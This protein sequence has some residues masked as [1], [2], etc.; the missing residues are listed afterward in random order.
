MWLFDLLRRGDHGQAIVETAFVVP[1]LLFACVGGADL[2]RAFAMQLAVQNGARAGAE[3]YALDKTPSVAA[4][5]QHAIDEINRTPGLNATAAN[6][7]VSTAQSD[8]VTACV[9]P[10]TIASPCYVTVEVIYQFRTMAAWPFIPNVANF[11]R[12]TIVRVFK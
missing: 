5:Q 6:V 1:L 3:A 4:T 10:P 2:A 9:S 12:T 8:G 11:D 7:V